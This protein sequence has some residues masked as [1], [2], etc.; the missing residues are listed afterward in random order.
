MAASELFACERDD[1]S[2]AV[3]IAGTVADPSLQLAIGIPREEIL[4][5]SEMS[6]A[7]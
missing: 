7:Y 5:P 2:S 3:E 6:S 4:H 1:N